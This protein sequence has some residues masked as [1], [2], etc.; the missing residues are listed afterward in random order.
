MQKRPSSDELKKL[1]ADALRRRQAEDI[2][3][4]VKAMKERILQEMGRRKWV[5]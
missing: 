3:R 1:Q 4:L 2:A 5:N